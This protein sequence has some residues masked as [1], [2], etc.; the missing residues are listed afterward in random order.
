MKLR[1]RHNLQNPDFEI[2]KKGELYVLSYQGNPFVVIDT[3]K[4]VTKA[5]LNMDGIDGLVYV[6]AGTIEWG[7]DFQP[8]F[9]CPNP[10]VVFLYNATDAQHMMHD[11]RFKEMGFASRHH[12]GKIDGQRRIQLVNVIEDL[13]LVIRNIADRD[14]VTHVTGQPTMSCATLTNY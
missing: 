11:E 5:D 8:K 12:G 4:P 3:Y 9:M 7:V 6:A 2:Q 14:R 13:E 10:D 1:N